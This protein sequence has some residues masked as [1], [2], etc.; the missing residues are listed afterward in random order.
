MNAVIQNDAVEPAWVGVLKSQIESL[1]F[2]T[3]QVVVHDARVVQIEKTEKVRFDKPG[4]RPPA[5]PED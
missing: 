3:V 4:S 1:R 5:A 2:G